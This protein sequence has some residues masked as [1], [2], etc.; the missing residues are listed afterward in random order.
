MTADTNAS[1][2]RRELMKPRTGILIAAWAGVS[3]PLLAFARVPLTRV[4]D[5]PSWT[6]EPADIVA[7]P[8]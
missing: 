7:E 8:P 2:P 6:A 5:Q 3:W 4:L 1:D